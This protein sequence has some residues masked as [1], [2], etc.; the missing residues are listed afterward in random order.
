VALVALCSVAFV[1]GLTLAIAKEVPQLDPAARRARS[2][3]GI[4][5]TRNTSGRRIL[6]VLR[7]DESR[8]I[9]EADQIS[10][11]VK[12]AI[13][14]VED[15]RFYEHSGV[16]LIGVL[17][18]AWADIQSQSVVQGGSTIT[19][20]FVKNAYVRNERT[21]ARK[22]R[23]AAFA[24][25]LE[26]RGGWSKERILTAYLNTI[27]FG[28]GAYGIQQ[29]AR[30]YFGID[31]SE[32]NLPQSALLAGINRDPSL[33]DPAQHPSA[34][35][36]RRRFVLGLMREQRKITRGQYA[37]AISTPLPRTEDIRLPGQVGP[38]QH[39]VNYVK[40]QLVSQYG[41]DRVFGGGLEV[42]TT[43]DLDM[44]DAAAAA[45][46][47]VLPDEGG[48]SAALVAMDPR[49]GAVKAMV[50]GMN[51]RK[52]QF[53][54]ATQA[55][56]QPGSSF[57]PIVLATAF[58]LGIAPETEFASKPVDIVAGDRVW[59]VTN[60]ENAY[61]GTADLRSA[62]VSSDNAVYAQ[63]TDVV[64]PA[65]VVR[66]AHALGIRSELPSFFSIGLGAVAVNPLD[67]TRAYATIANG[68]RRVDGTLLGD[69]PRVIERVKFR[70][71]GRTAVN[72]P[73]DVPVLAP[74]KAE[75]ITSILEDVVRD[76]TGRR[77]RL[78]GRQVAGKTGTTDN[79]GD[80]WFIGYTPELVTAVWVGYPNGLRPM[81]TEF[82]GRPVSGSTLPALIWKDFMASLPPTGADPA[83]TFAPTPYLGATPT[84]VVFRDGWRLDNGYCTDS[85]VLQYFPGEAPQAQA[86]CYA[87][88]VRVPTVIGASASVAGE[89]LARGDL[90][91]SLVYIPAKPG[92]RP[93]IVTGQ[94]PRA[95]AFLSAGSD[96]KV[97]VT[98]AR[99]GLLPNLVG[100]SLTDVRARTTAENLRLRVRFAR[101]EAETVLSQT[102]PA[103]IASGP[104]LLVTVVVGSGASRPPGATGSTAAP[105]DAPAG[106]AGV[107]AAGPSP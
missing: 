96:V 57:K 11:Y 35:L 85:V 91:S 6:A 43:I 66:T 15:K 12:Q 92:T 19:Q 87:D 30:T 20:Q 101:G 76:G 52:S 42:E 29:A 56:R 45:I 70:R 5:Y 39:F 60:Y 58:S 102:P 25:Q 86:Q 2:I 95:G 65:N 28:H 4:I 107:P 94:E 79:Y 74:A 105:G 36:G 75:M 24:W 84:R 49:T 37:W 23:E 22:V 18:A 73:K 38:A 82:G 32:L 33:Y 53:N 50:G 31:A 99:H 80:A 83:A 17:R 71:T 41:A 98:K 104:G 61:T 48:P 51:Y 1:F 62:M 103:G 21:L 59:H 47:N 3:D 16:D 13:V 63:L 10:P 40:D 55:E 72:A 93:G 67:M 8:V 26:R 81:L 14:S 90:T 69:R 44:Q 68:G 100:S 64:R 88:E 9:V 27:Y 106:A 77:A 97:I 78:P 54:L 46:R 89:I 34:A 7:G